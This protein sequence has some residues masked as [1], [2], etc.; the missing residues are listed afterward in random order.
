MIS[1][2]FHSDYLA[3][4]SINV[5]NG[6]KIIERSGILYYSVAFNNKLIDDGKIGSFFNVVLNKLEECLDY[7]DKEFY[8][9]IPTNMVLLNINKV[10]SNMKSEQIIELNNLTT[11]IKYGNKISES[12]SKIIYPFYENNKINSFLSVYFFKNYIA[13][14]QKAFK[15]NDLKLNGI[16]VNILNALNTVSQLKNNE[17]DKFSLF[18]FNESDEI[19][20]LQV[21]KD[22]ITTYL[23]YRKNN[24]KLVFYAKAG[25]YS[26][27][28]VDLL[29][30]DFNDSFFSSMGKIY[31]IG[32]KK[33][34]EKIKYFSDK[35]SFIDVV[36]PFNTKKTK[37]KELSVIENLPSY[38]YND[39]TFVEATGILF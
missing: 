4:I 6:K 7:Y 35:Y 5:N 22:K 2:S 11:Q 33:N 30:N 8:I 9:S 18:C 38:F 27:E 36:N 28:I 20:Y 26:E 3:F 14:I 15:N 31:L 10:N 23:R 32:T 12:F 34:Q 17:L 24:N 21:K 1:V 39:N 37:D 16:Y 29:K 19:E 13:E 25:E